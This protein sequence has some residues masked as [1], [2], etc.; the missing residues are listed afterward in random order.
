M[1]GKEGAIIAPA[2]TVRLLA[3]RID[4]FALDFWLERNSVLSFILMVGHIV[5]Q[6]Y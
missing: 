5:L 6:Y 1:E 4:I 3:V 2:I